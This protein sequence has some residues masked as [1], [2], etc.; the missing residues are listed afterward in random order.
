MTKEEKNIS[1]SHQ[2]K[3]ILL[4]PIMPHYTKACDMMAP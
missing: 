2:H 3:L 1:K 4:D